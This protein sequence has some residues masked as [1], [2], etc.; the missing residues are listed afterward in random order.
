MTTDLEQ[1]LRGDLAQ[2]ERRIEQM[3]DALDVARADV[4]RLSGLADDRQDRIDHLEDIIREIS[5]ECARA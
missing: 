1:E 4:E 3:D 5:D 2:A